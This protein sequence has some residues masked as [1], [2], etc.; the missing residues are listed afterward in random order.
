[1]NITITKIE[2]CLP[3]NIL[4]EVWF[5]SSKTVDSVTATLSTSFHFMRNEN[6]AAMIAWADIT[7][8]IVKGWITDRGLED[9]LDDE[10]RRINNP[11]TAFGLPWE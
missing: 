6:S 1:M 11:P 7:E 4:M 3:E 10:L 8:D 5:D 9:M 2:R